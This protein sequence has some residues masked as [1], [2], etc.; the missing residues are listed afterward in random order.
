MSKSFTDACG[1]LSKML[2]LWQSTVPPSP[3][4]TFRGD[5]EKKKK[6]LQRHETLDVQKV[7]RLHQ[8]KTRENR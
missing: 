2:L 3:T 4:W 5:T 1:E 6:Y 8:D 7:R